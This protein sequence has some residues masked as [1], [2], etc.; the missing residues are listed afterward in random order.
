MFELLATLVALVLHST[1][2]TINMI[3]KVYFFC[4]LFIT[5]IAIISYSLM[6]ILHMLS[7]PD[8]CC[9]LEVTLITIIVLGLTLQFLHVSLFCLR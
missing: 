8:S 3:L 7:N 4:E 6:F 5:L 1:M 2:D 9:C